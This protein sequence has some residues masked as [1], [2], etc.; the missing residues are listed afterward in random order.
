MNKIEEKARYYHDYMQNILSGNADKLP[1]G[2]YFLDSAC[3][4]ALR[5]K[6]INMIE[7]DIYRKI[8]LKEVKI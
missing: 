1:E 4:C 2:E 3:K 5:L 6:A 8:L 7:K